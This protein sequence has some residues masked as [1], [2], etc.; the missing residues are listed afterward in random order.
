M[1]GARGRGG[2]PVAVAVLQEDVLQHDL[3][4]NNNNNT[5]NTTSNNNNTNKNTNTSTNR[6]SSSGSAALGERVDLY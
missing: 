2:V 4:T 5:N 1:R 3:L 6:I